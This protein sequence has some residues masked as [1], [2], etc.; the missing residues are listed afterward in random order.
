[1]SWLLVGS[2]GRKWW[3]ESHVTRVHQLL[4][5]GHVF[6]KHALK[7]LGVIWKFTSFR[8]RNLL[9]FLCSSIRGIFFRK[10][11]SDKFWKRVTRLRKTSLVGLFPLSKNPT[12]IF[13]TASKLFEW[14]LSRRLKQK[15][16]YQ[17]FSTNKSSTWIGVKKQFREPPP[18]LNFLRAL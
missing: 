1:M 18:L 6:V 17:N 2:V 15:N 5:F 12:L 9:Y 3:S 11:S 7:S 10:K 16:G 14:K 13:Q 4:V 8:V